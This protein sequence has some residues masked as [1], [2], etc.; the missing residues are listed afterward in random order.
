[1]L[2]ALKYP[3]VQA[4]MAGGVST[5]AL[6]AAVSEAGGLGFLAGGY[7][8][9]EELE[10]EI[11][12]LRGRTAAGFGINLFVP[13]PDTADP[14]AL[15]AYRAKLLK[16]AETLNVSLGAPDF[17]DDDYARKIAL[18]QAE[19]VPVVSFTFGCP[20][21]ETVQTLQE[22]GIEVAVTVT[23]PA[24]AA[25]ALDAGADVLCLQGA[26]AGGH[27]G[28]FSN[29][30]DLREDIG[31]LV[32]IRLVRTLTD[33]PVIAAGGIMDGAGVRAALAAGAD[34]AQLG[35]AFLLCPES[36]TNA[37]Y[38]KALTDPEFTATRITRAFTG[39][40]ARG[41][42]N[43]FMETYD[44][45]APAAYPQVHHLTQR[46]RKEAAARG[47]ADYMSLWA[48]QGYRMARAIPAAQLIHELMTEFHGKQNL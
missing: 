47:Q 46:L 16:E 20:A 25:L 12:E 45:E 6:A 32:L 7:K 29:D 39:R 37:A 33:K 18:V 5:P 4:P 38:R 1:M 3:I 31:L 35:T 11:R 22:K 10:K 8:T 34:A 2:K 40:R 15:E 30:P 41:L 19:R 43:R 48:G 9:S 28:T 24:E 17:D 23:N 42:V 44:A 26:E 14:Q 36:G 13:G 21:K 27:R